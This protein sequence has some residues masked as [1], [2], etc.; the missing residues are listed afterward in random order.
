MKTKIF[1]ISSDPI[2]E[3]GMDE[4]VE[5][6]RNDG[7]IVYPTETYYALGANGFSGMAIQDVF[8]LKKRE[9]SKPLSL[10]ISD[11][12]MLAPIVS[13]VPPLFRPL[14]KEFWPGPLT[15]ILKASPKMPV[16]LQEEG[17]IG[18]RL[19]GHNWVRSLVSR[20]R[21]PITAT[22]ANISGEKEISTASEA[23]KMFGGKVDLIVDGGRTPGMAPSTIVDMSRG[24]PRLI[25]EGRISASQ[26][27]NIL[28]SLSDPTS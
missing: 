25:R 26:L 10:I 1:E 18:V 6:L 14:I 23:K 24:I 9:S 8:R 4:I 7:I 21:F 16:E 13:D 19:T 15:I 11:I 5:V 20:A 2:A 3:D 17:T 27:K 28:P 12:S 22:S